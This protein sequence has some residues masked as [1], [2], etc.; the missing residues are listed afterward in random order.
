[1]TTWNPSQAGYPRQ[2]PGVPDTE[3]LV[4]FP[5]R[6]RGL[7]QQDHALPRLRRRNAGGDEDRGF[8]R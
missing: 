3:L 2:H 8:G 4:R 1:M 7:R 5:L 6:P